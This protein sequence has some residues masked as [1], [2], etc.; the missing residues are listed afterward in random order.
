MFA[1][2]VLGQTTQ[3]TDPAPSASSRHVWATGFGQA[4]TLTVNATT[5]YAGARFDTSLTL[6]NGMALMPYARLAVEHE[7]N[8]TR[9]I[10]A[11]FQALPGSGYTV[12]GAPAAANVGRVDLGLKLG[13]RAGLV[14]YTD[15]DGAFSDAGNGYGGHAGVKFS[16]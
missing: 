8:T 3:W 12:Y 15:V 10:T 13:V 6:A 7:T 14:V 2:A 11:S 5:V 1:T 16:W 4:S 9:S